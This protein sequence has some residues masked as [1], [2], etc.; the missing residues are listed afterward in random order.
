METRLQRRVLTVPV[1]HLHHQT[2]GKVAVLLVLWVLHLSVQHVLCT[3]VPYVLHARAKPQA[4][5]WGMLWNQI[6]P[7][8][9]ISGL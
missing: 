4:A 5:L 2:A 6:I 3:R 9:R 7:S 1:L 8:G